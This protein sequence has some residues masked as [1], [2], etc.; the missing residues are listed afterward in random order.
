MKLTYRGIDY[1][2]NPPQVATATGEV[3]GKYRGQDWRFCNL[4]KPPVLQ[5]SYNLTYRG[6]KYSNNPVS[7]VS[8]TD[9]PLTISEKARILMLK[10]ERSEIQRDQ[11]MLNRLADEVGL[12]LNDTGFY[13]PA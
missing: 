5:P 12:N 7:A 9:S 13:N 11:S 6:V 2:Y 10:R 1:Q 4:K 8:G 3:A